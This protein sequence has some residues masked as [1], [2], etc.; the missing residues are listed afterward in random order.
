MT[1]KKLS[2]VAGKSVQEIEKT[3]NCFD[4]LSQIE[5]D[6]DCC[7]ADEYDQE[8]IIEPASTW[9]ELADKKLVNFVAEKECNKEVQGKDEQ[10]K[11]FMYSYYH[12]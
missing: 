11:Y 2:T 3:I 8:V 6:A 4:M 1:N 12:Q 5:K 10:N 7:V 9:K